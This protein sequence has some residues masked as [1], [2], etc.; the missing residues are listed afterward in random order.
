MQ[1]LSFFIVFSIISNALLCQVQEW[2]SFQGSSWEI[3]NGK[4][5]TIDGRAAFSGI[6]LLRDIEFS[7]GIIEWDI[8]TTGQRSYAG[9]IFRYQEGG[10]FE[11]FYI[12][13]HKANGLNYDAFQY[14]P[15]YHGISCWQ[16]FHGQ[17]RTMAA[18]IPSGEW[19][20]FSI[21]INGRNA[22]VQ[23]E[24]NPG[25][26][27]AI[28]NLDIESLSG[29]VGIKCP[30]DGSA[31]ISGFKVKKRQATPETGNKMTLQPAPGVISGWELSQVFPNSRIRNE[32][33]PLQIKTMDWVQV[34]CETNG[35][36]NLTKHLFRNTIE[37]GWVYARKILYSDTDT[38]KGF[39][40]GYSDNV[41]LFLNGTPL[42]S[43]SNGFTSRDPGY[44]GLIG[45]FDKVYLPLERGK[46]E[47]MLL[48]GEQFG[49][50][51][52]MMRESRVEYIDAGL[53]ELWHIEG[54]L[55]YPESLTLDHE[56]GNLLVTNFIAEGGGF[57]S[58][59]RPDGSIIE[60]RYIEGF[61]SP[62]GIMVKGDNI[63]VADRAGVT[64]LNRND[65]RNRKLI[66]L[67]GSVFPNDIA[68]S[69]DGTVYVSDSG[70][71]QIFRI[72]SGRAEVWLKGAHIAAPNALYL[73]G[74][75]LYI[76][77]SGISSV[78][79]TDTSGKNLEIVTE[80]PGEPVIDGI[81]SLS[82]GTLIIGDHSG[83]LYS[84]DKYGRPEVL[85]NTGA[86]GMR[87]ADFEYLPG[88]RML[89]IPGLYSNR[90]RCFLVDI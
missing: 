64:V 82:D 13:P 7:D 3:I 67:P 23:M 38:V 20:H 84:I 56:T 5:D 29:R 60:P 17:G 88:S 34:H 48:V 58:L 72:R 4:T 42:Y 74:E 28:D 1:G 8:Y 77:S 55:N 2:D 14:T 85:M 69:E 9:V 46:N 36:V 86:S 37:P 22:R 39:D 51:G 15:V 47:I 11:E 59:L 43:G 44:A 10:D 26:T 31:W 63:Y 89:V 66:S 50:W 40:I 75:K 79:V 54:E 52:F 35:M 6:A 57:I 53:T 16:L 80:L 32:Q 65:H 78:V 25:Y 83:Y 41:T 33:Y 21:E 18:V 12:R 49:G 90:I 27:M 45:Y 19:V 24:G 81:S 62:T 76:G 68:V 30:V 71:D 73:V 87:M 61:Q 70:G